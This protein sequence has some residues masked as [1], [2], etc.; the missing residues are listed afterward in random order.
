M[1]ATLV[2]PGHFKISLSKDEMEALSLRYDDLSYAN[3]RTRRVLHGLLS[4]CGQPFACHGKLLIEVF[5]APRQGCHICYTALQRPNQAAYAFADLPAVETAL[6]AWDAAPK[7]SAFY[8]W[9]GQYV[10]FINEA[11]PLLHE[12][13]A[14][15][16]LTER[17]AAEHGKCLIAHNAVNV[18]RETL[19]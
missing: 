10:L 8:R 11:S 14:P 2:E 3:P 19:L 4:A 18:L 17:H 1:E 7:H 12:F 15:I 16:A 9:R 5:P 6:R 13:A